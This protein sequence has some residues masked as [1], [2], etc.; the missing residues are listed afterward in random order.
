MLEQR[1]RLGSSRLVSNTRA[2]VRV[3]IKVH[4]IGWQKDPAVFDDQ[5]RNYSRS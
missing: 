2:L 4:H 5:S 3:V 1:S